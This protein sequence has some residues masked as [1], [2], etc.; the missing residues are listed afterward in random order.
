MPEHARDRGRSIAQAA[1]REEHPAAEVFVSSLG[2]K[3]WPPRADDGDDGTPPTDPAVSGDEPLVP[4]LRLVRVDKEGITQPRNDGSAGSAL[5]RIPIVLD[6]RP[7]PEWAEL[8]VQAWNNPPQW[9][10]MHRAGIARVQ[11]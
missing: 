8:F 3:P 9:S 1:A 11:G 2:P 5:Y 6:R 7:D 4:P 10:N